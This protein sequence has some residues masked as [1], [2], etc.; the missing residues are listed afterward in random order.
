MVQT[1]ISSTFLKNK[2]ALRYLC[3]LLFLNDLEFIKLLF[4][5]SLSSGKYIMSHLSGLLTQIFQNF[6]IADFYFPQFL[7]N[8]PPVSK[9][10]RDLENFIKKPTTHSVKDLWLILSVCKALWPQLFHHSSKFGLPKLYLKPWFA[11]LESALPWLQ[12]LW[13]GGM[14]FATPFFHYLI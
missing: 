13:G 5:L 8:Y 2:K 3:L 4:I 7:C 10:S 6:V 1:T 12:V 11:L 14:K 9:V